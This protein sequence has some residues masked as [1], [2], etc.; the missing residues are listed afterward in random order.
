MLHHLSSSK[1]H[2]VFSFIK[3]FLLSV[4]DT[5]LFSCFSRF[6]Q[7]IFSVCVNYCNKITRVVSI[8]TDFLREMCC[9]LKLL[10]FKNIGKFGLQREE[11]KILPYP[12]HVLFWPAP[13]PLFPVNRIPST[14][15]ALPPAPSAFDLGGTVDHG[16]PSSAHKVDI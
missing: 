10:D 3:I 16:P 2:Q 12:P 15:L 7:S 5:D 4:K 8:D 9:S 14:S 6:M 1:P 11:K 13:Y